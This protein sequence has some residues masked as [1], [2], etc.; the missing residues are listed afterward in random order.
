M[1]IGQPGWRQPALTYQ[2]ATASPVPMTTTDRPNPIIMFLTLSRIE[3]SN[4]EKPPPRLMIE[5]VTDK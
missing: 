1:R 5:T 3:F 2:K 4:M